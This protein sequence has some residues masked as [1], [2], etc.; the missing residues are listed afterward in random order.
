MLR[1]CAGLGRAADRQPAHPPPQPPAS[2]P[3]C[4][5]PRLPRTRTPTWL[6]GA[7]GRAT[8]PASGQQGRRQQP[9]RR[10]RRPQ[11][12]RQPGRP[13]PAAVPAAADRTCHA[14]SGS[15]GHV[16]AWT[17][18]AS[19]AQLPEKVGGAPSRP[20]RRRPRRAGQ[21]TPN[22]L[23]SPPREQLLT[24]PRP[25]TGP[26]PCLQETAEE[27]GRRIAAQWTSDPE[28]AGAPAGAK[29]A[30]VGFSSLLYRCVCPVF[31][32]QQ[33]PAGV[34]A[35][36]SSLLTA[37]PAPALLPWACRPLPV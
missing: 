14:G 33:A 15:A 23:P 27:R 5:A 19:L 24:Q 32:R 10:Q 9:A 20:P 1:G 25:A 22:P 16:L 34:L 2:A 8:H 11:R 31:L 18:A 17:V 7:G 36:A 4:A 30:Q 21:G 37:F 28:A 29:S 26:W 13:A 12:R 35:P 3:A 6:G